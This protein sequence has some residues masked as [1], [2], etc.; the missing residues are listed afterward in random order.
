MRCITFSDT[1]P[2]LTTEISFASA[3]LLAG[4]DDGSS[5]ISTCSGSGMVVDAFSDFLG[6]SSV[7]FCSFM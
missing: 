1:V 6:A 7:N 3:L 4:A 5:S 2:E